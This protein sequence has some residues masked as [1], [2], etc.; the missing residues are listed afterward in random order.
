VEGKGVDPGASGVA[1]AE[2]LGDFVVG[3]SGG[4]VDGAADEGVVPGALGGTGEKEMGVTAGD[5]E[6]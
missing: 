2:E 6:G 1:E 5:D 4:V 3:F